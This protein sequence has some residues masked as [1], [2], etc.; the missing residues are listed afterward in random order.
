MMMVRTRK[1]ERF[2]SNPFPI[3]FSDSLAEERDRAIAGKT[4]EDEEREKE[5]KERAE[6][7]K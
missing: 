4:K 2:L 3:N 1:A 5:E 6:V 7:L